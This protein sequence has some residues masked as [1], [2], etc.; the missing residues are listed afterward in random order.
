M[1]I[2]MVIVMVNND[3]TGWLVVYLPLWKIWVNWDDDIP[4]MM[5]MSYKSPWFQSPFQ[6]PPISNLWTHNTGL[7][8]LS[9]IYHIL[10]KVVKFHGSKHFQ[11]PHFPWKWSS[12]KDPQSLKDP[13]DSHQKKSEKKSWNAKDLEMWKQKTLTMIF[14]VGRWREKP[15][16]EQP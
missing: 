4:N 11:S 9:H 12:L 14:Q 1:V 2:M 13:P 8:G 10:W 16:F 15:V 7:S 3:I 5:G 6:S